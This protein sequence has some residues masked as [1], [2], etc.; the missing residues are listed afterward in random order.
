MSNA[1]LE[2]NLDAVAHN[3]LWLK[4]K[5]AKGGDAG[6]VVKADAYGLGAAQIAPALYRANCRHFFVCTFDEGLTVR[7]AV[8]DTNAQIYILYGR[9]GASLADFAAHALTPVLNSLGD[10]ED[11]AQNPTPK[12]Q[13]VILHLDTGMNRLGLPSSEVIQLQNNQDILK[14]L[15]IRYVMSHLAC[16]DEPEHPKN[17]EQLAKFKALTAALPIP[18]RYSLANSAGI[19]LGSDYHFD[20]TRAGC[21]LYGI[22]PQGTAV[23]PMQNVVT[24]KSNILQ[25]REIA[26]GETVGYGAVFRA[27][28]PMILA[29]LAC[30]YADG[31]LRSLTDKGQVVI[32]AKKYP[33]IGRVSMDSIIIDITDVV[34]LPKTGDSV[35]ILGD[36]Q[37]VDEVAAQAGTI[38]YEI[39]TALGKRYTRIYK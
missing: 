4:N 29:T 27:A 11:W 35:E 39:L 30:G 38:G 28:R 10:I 20:L 3:Y 5:L 16:A 36:H 19:L 2:I 17:A 14:S 37:T 9:S 26:K 1:T 31:Y 12:K 34:S 25:I 23:N 15:D 18:C 33:V 22:N 6:A 13:P 32:G 7:K 8:P 21:G 24:L